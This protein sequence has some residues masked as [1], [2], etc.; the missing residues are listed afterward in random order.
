MYNKRSAMQWCGWRVIITRMT[1]TK[2]YC[3]WDDVNER[4]SLLLLGRTVC[5]GNTQV[6][7]LLHFI[8]HVS[9]RKS[10]VRGSWGCHLQCW[11]KNHWFYLFNKNLCSNYILIKFP[12]V[13]EHS[14]LSSTQCF[15]HVSQRYPA[16][17]S[18]NQNL[19]SKTTC[20]KFRCYISLLFCVA[21]WEMYRASL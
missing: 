16:T 21:N 10:G 15:A 5:Y 3:H 20:V 8:L 19:S 11:E 14:I 13:A 9:P 17:E 1:E 18:E 12:F 2:V 4:V 6:Q 7:Y